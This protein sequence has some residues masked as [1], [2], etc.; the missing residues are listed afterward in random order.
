MDGRKSKQ[1]I[2]RIKRRN[3]DKANRQHKRKGF[4]ADSLLEFSEGFM[5]AKAPTDP[6]V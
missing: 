5:F 1:K 2:N 6:V 4:F 3:R